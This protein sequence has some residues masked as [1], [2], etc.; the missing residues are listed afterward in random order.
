MERMKKL[1]APR[2]AADEAA[3]SA[4]FEASKAIAAELAS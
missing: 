1:L 4:V 2:A 3:L